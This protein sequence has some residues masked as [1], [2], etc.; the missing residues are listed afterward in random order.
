MKLFLI[1]ACLLLGGCG[2]LMGMAPSMQ[3]CDEVVYHRKGEQIQL[4]AQCTT[5]E[6]VKGLGVMGL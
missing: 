6:R 1:T 4:A 2:T 5:S 3:Y